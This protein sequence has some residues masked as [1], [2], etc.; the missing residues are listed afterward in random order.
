MMWGALAFATEKLAER[1]RSLPRPTP[2]PAP[3]GRAAGFVLDDDTPSKAARWLVR[4]ILPPDGLAFLAGQSGAG[5]SFVA[6]DLAVSLATGA[7]WFGHATRERVGVAILAA[8]GGGGLKRRLDA[9][10]RHR[11]ISEPLPIAMHPAVPNLRDAS[12]RTMIEAS[13]KD[14]D[15]DFRAR[16]GVRL[17]VVFIDTMGAAFALEDE[18]ANAEANT[19]VRAL[20]SMGAAT[21]ALIMPVHHVGKDATKGMRGASAWH[22][23]GDVVLMIAAR[24]NDLGKVEAREAGISK[25][26]DGEEGPL[27]AFGLVDVQLG[28]DEHGDAFGSCAVEH[29]PDE[30]TGQTRPRKKPKGEPRNLT[31]LQ[32]VLRVAGKPMSSEDARKAF[33]AAYGGSADAARKAFKRATSDLAQAGV[34]LVDGDRLELVREAIAEWD[35]TTPFA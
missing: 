10:K 27:G 19:V 16:F 13:L 2:P 31:V 30:P 12:A 7:P 17:G 3:A 18:S 8:E 35:S 21:G 33:G 23:A 25:S 9:A 26:R 5:K 29:R 28:I 20:R 1:V 14:I 22:A 15:R 6:V 32:D 34:V 11:G 4:G 24:R